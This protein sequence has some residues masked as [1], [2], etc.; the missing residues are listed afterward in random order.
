MIRHF[1]AFDDNQVERIDPPDTPRPQLERSPILPI[2]EA[3]KVVAAYRDPLE[4][5]H[6]PGRAAYLLRC[7]RV[8]IA[9]P[10]EFETRESCYAMLFHEL[11]HSTGRQKRV[12]RGIGRK[13][14]PFGSPDD[15]KEELVAEFG[16]ALCSA[17]A[18]ISSPTIEQSAAS[19]DEWR[20]KLRDDKNLLVQAATVKGSGRRTAFLA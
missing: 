7:N 4:I 14:A 15:S 5:K 11:S 16:S 10:G 2:T 17:F 6:M 13:L 3:E 9:Q 1:V 12:A 8:E 20:R 18:G 19:I